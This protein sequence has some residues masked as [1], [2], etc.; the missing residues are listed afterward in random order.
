MTTIR[1]GG[2]RKV[3]LRSV[4]VPLVMLLQHACKE[5]WARMRV[6]HPARVQYHNLNLKS[7]KIYSVRYHVHSENRTRAL[8]RD[9]RWLLFYSYELRWTLRKC[10]EAHWSACGGILPRTALTCILLLSTHLRFILLPL[11][12]YWFSCVRRENM[13]AHAFRWDIHWSDRGSESGMWPSVHSVCVMLW[14]HVFFPSHF[15]MSQ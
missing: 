14:P 8:V 6:E 15:W 11:L 3:I 1:G 2:I 5:R 13:N 4:H 12:L 9:H 10:S 7:R